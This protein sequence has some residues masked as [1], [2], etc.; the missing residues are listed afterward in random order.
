MRSIVI[1]VIA[2]AG[3]IALAACSSDDSNRG[4]EPTPP[5]ADATAAATPSDTVWLCK[6]GLASNPCEGDLSATVI[7]GDGT[8]SI[9]KASSA[10]D[11]PIDCFYVYP[12]ASNEPRA[13]A[14][15][16]ITPEVAAV[17]TLQAARFSQVCSVY[18]P[19]YRQLTAAGVLGLPLPEGSAPP[20][21]AVAYDDI[22][23]AWQ[24]YLVH[25]NNGRGIVLLGHSQGAFILGRLI[26]DQVDGD[27]DLRGR[28]VSAIIL[29]GNVA[30]ADSSSAPGGSFDNIPA[31]SSAAQAGCVIAY[32]SFTHMP[33][34]GS[35]F[36]RVAAEDAATSH[37]LCTDP[38]APS[39]D[40]GNLMTYVPAHPSPMIG[41]GP[42]PEVSTPWIAYPD[43]FEGQCASQDGA[44]WL[45]VN[46]MRRDG[47]TRPQATESLGAGF[48]LHLLDFNLALGNL[49]DI[50]RE[51]SDAWVESHDG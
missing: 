13:N 16:D 19:V 41:F 35:I 14:S 23:S 45:Q 15:L 20:D 42:Q 51:Q 40:A 29:G 36:G 6:P 22:A 44:T 46:D 48:G 21:P 30:V 7:H 49:V 9:E 26:A 2:I 50:V 31:C 33:P 10:Q 39:G 4:R 11:P 34:A 3:A 47:D 32:S 43:L 24:D 18:V 1:I 12:T 37:V 8:T 38:T 25:Y 28:L 5:G 27:A 17:A